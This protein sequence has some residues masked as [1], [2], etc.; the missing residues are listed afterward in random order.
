MLNTLRQY[1]LA[2]KNKITNKLFGVVSVYCRGKKNGT[3][4]IS[5]ITGPFTQTPVEFYSD[6]HSNYW[7]VT[8]IARLFTER[9]YNVDIINWNNT[10]Y[11]PRKK[12]AVCLDMQYNL[13]RLSAHLPK[14]CIK[15]MH[16]VASYPEFQNNAEQTRI[17]ALK[18]RKGILFPLKRT[19]PTTSNPGIADFLCGYGNKTVHETYSRF[20]KKIIPIP[21]PIMETY[22][23]PEKNF[24]LARN[25]FLWFGGGGAILKGLDLVVE[26][27]ATLPHLHLTIIGPAAYE[28]EF[29]NLYAEE[30]ALP[31]ITRYGRPHLKE[32][33]GKSI[34][35]D[36]YVYDIINQCAGVIGLSASEGGGGAT[37]Q[38]M[39]AGLFPI[40]TPQTGIDEKTPSII[41]ENPTLE[42]IKDAIETFSNLP[43]E[44]IAKLSKESWEFTN[45]YHTKEAFTKN[46]ENFIDNILKLPR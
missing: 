7:V 1:I 26:T 41:I 18:K 2:Y 35:G 36:K 5:F 11:I 16:L 9:G 43:V 31:N 15:V 39:H 6:P 27:F 13:E 23:F 20:G 30:L 19:D 37:V 21:I 44:T 3:I 38:A 33:N 24:T 4:L 42:N 29:E 17:E 45:K 28:K 22:D 40:V 14:S 34:I 12:Y 8:E 32:K 10:R 25:N 46:Y